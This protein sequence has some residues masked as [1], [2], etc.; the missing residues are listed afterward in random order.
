[1]SKPPARTRF[2]RIGQLAAK[3]G[4][5]TKAVRLYEARGLLA[6]DAHSDSGYRLYGAAALARLNEIRVL[7]RAGFTLA[8]TGRLLQREGSAAAL[9]AARIVA[10]RGEVRKRRGRW[11]NWNARGAGWIRHRTTSVNSWRT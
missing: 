5:S 9:I 8:E 2:L 11:M 1:M 7:Q 4:V 10:L 3:S 6:P